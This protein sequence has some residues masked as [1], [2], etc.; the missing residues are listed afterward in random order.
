MSISQRCCAWC[1]DEVR[2]TADGLPIH[3]TGGGPVV[4]KCRDCGRES[5]DST[6]A[7]ANLCPFCGGI[8]WEVEHTIL[9]VPK[10]D[11]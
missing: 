8:N 1:G 10:G 7:R 5:Q 2:H 11:I 4:M 9:P 3:N 6:H